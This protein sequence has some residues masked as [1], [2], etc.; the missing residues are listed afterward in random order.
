AIGDN[1]ENLP[2]LSKKCDCTIHVTVQ[3]QPSASPFHDV[4][5]ALP[6]DP[7]KSKATFRWR[8][9]ARRGYTPTGALSAPAVSIVCRL[10]APTSG[11]TRLP[12]GS[13]VQEIADGGSY[14]P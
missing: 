1:P 8:P 10:P 2:I 7:A 12:P 4:S 6:A 14:A 13:S 3:P 9:S 11:S 5:W